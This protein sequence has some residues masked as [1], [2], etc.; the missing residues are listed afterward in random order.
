MKYI[1]TLQDMIKHPAKIIE[2]RDY[3]ENAVIEC[4]VCKWNGSSV[5]AIINTDSHFAL[6]VSCPV[7]DK[8]LLVASYPPYSSG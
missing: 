1:P 3:N 4:P 2:Y 7:C 5:S 6:D 8:M